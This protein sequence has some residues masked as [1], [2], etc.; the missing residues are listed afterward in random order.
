MHTKTGSNVQVDVGQSKN[1]MLA[2]PIWLA[3]MF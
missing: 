2:M 1:K 3:Y